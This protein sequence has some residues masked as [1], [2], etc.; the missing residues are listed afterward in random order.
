V[1]TRQ[2]EL[3]Y[4]VLAYLFLVAGAV[5]VMLV[6]R[7]AMPDLWR[8]LLPLLRLRPG[9]WGGSM[10]L[11]A[12]MVF[13]I[14]QQA[15][16]QLAL[17]RLEAF[18]FFA[19]ELSKEDRQHHAVILSAPFFLPTFLLATLIL[20][21]GLTGS[22]PADLGLTLRRWPAN[23]TLGLFGML[24][25]TPPVLIFYDLVTQFFDREEY[26]FEE[27][28]KHH[29]P[30]WEW[31]VLGFQLLIVAPVAEEILFRGLLQGWLRRASLPGHLL[32]LLMT[33]LVSLIRKEPPPGK[34]LDLSPLI[35]A[36]G[37]AVLYILALYW[38]SRRYLPAGVPPLIWNLLPQPLPGHGNPDPEPEDTL[39]PRMVAPDAAAQR[40]WWRWQVV[41]AR[42][43][44]VGS[45]M[46]F[47]MYHTQIWPAPLPLFF[48]ALGLGWLAYRTQSLVGPI[49]LHATFNAVG[50]V[51]LIL[52]TVAPP[53]TNGKE[54]TAAQRP[55]FAGSTSNC[56][57][58]VWLPRRR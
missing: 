43:A 45:S 29:F 21:R 8:R 6:L 7:L 30:A 26:P 47:A 57:P 2:D 22:R 9:R 11:L 23:V 3:L 48:L 53:E 35:V 16:T 1:T 49:V 38:L 56:V 14:T 52:V 36:Q 31:V 20:L 17:E 37:V 4:T 40:T 13:I 10:V 15:T 54:Q 18:D 19:P 50:Y 46:L 58:G 34:E 33:L 41:N 5:L 24:L 27:L 39:P 28:V 32:L 42:L 25:L 44:I 51:V 12:F 55:A